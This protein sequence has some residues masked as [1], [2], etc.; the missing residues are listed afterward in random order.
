MSVRKC[1]DRDF[2]SAFSIVLSHSRQGDIQGDLFRFYHRRLFS[3][4]LVHVHVITGFAF[5]ASANNGIFMFGIALVFLVYLVG[6][7]A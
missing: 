5:A 2:R 4:R 1:V 6:E 3:L 7:L